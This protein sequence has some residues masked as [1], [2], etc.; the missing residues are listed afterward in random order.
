MINNIENAGVYTAL[1][2]KK[3]DISSVR[4]IL[5]EDYLDY[6]K[7]KDLLEEKE[8]LRESVSMEGEIIKIA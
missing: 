8:G 7:V 2:R 3:A 5:L 1:I 6:P 4:D